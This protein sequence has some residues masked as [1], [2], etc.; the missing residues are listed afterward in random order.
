MAYIYKISYDFKTYFSSL[1]HK[2]GKTQH[3]AL[4]RPPSNPSFKVKSVASANGQ[5]LPASADVDVD[6]F[7]PPSSYTTTYCDGIYHPSL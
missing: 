4:N 2:F 6:A 5:D 7:V 1:A 3:Q